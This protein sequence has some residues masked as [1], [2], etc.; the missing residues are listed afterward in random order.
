MK[1]ELWRPF[2][3]LDR[4]W[5]PMFRFP[6]LFEGREFDF[7]PSIDATRTDGELIIK[8]ELPGIDPAQDMEI[9]VDE[10]FLMIKGEKSAEKEVKDEDRYV[11]ERRYG[12]FVRRIPVPEGVSADKVSASYKDGVLTVKVLLP[13][14]KA[15]F[16]PRKIPVEMSTS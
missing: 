3:E 9:T 2:F 13:E 8:A 7:R 4:D 14:E 5:D 12:K 11:H 1:L 6:R 16:E 10:D 15:K